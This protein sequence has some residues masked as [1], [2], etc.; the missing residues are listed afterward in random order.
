MTMTIE[1]LGNLRASGGRYRK[2]Q[3]DECSGEIYVQTDSGF[4]FGATMRR[5]GMTTR[6]REAAMSIAQEWLEGDRRR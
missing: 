5:I 6:R 2:V 4:L 3:W 1:T